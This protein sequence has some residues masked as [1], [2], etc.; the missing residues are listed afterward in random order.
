MADKFKFYVICPVC[1]GIGE[2]N[3]AYPNGTTCQRCV[4]ETEP[5]GV[6]IFDGLRHVYAGRFEE[7]EAEPPPP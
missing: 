5:F 1:N 4:D 6:K 7:V 3:W 2:V